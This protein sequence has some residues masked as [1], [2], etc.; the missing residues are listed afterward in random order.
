M[1]WVTP[2]TFTSGN[3]LTAAQ[4]Q[5]LTGD[6][7]ETAVAKATFTGEYFVAEGANTL[8]ARRVM[9]DT[10]DSIAT[11]TNT[12]YVHSGMPQVTV[13]T[14]SGALVFLFS[15]IRN[16][17]ASQASFY[18]FQVTGTTTSA[19]SD[20]AALHAG[21]FVSDFAFTAST[22]IHKTGLTAGSGNVFTAGVRV[23]GGTGTWDHR[24]IAVL[25]L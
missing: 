11:T 9:S 21:K 25:P 14:N 2:P 5:I 4:M 19:A 22:V 8:G 6:L 18:G 3:V 24:R 13:T 23:T 16:D 17:T 7:A 20:N 10:L 12:S 15:Y 1:A